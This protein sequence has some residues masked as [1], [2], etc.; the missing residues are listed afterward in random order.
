MN[1]TVARRYAT[2]IFELAKESGKS[3]QIVR[4]LRSIETALD[5]KAEVRR[6]FVS[7]VVDR[8]QK[9]QVLEKTFGAGVDRI[10]LNAVLL[11]VRKRRETLLSAIVEQC[12]ALLL[13]DQ[14]RL[15]LEIVSARP[16]APGELE[17]M[18][19]R[20]SRVYNKR[21]EVSSSVDPTL[22]GGVRITMGDRY[23]DGSI[24][25][26]LDELARQLFAKS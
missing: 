24:S 19:E 23:I 9:A 15:S 18:V 6:F 8:T 13:A 21:F 3:E 12:E 16:P 11:L 10:A 1:Q 14:N 2:A 25:G 7:P 20:L 5:S 26:R 22:L 4:D 17:R